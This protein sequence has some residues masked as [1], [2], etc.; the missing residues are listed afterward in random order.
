MMKEEVVWRCPYTDHSRGVFAFRPD[1]GRLAVGRAGG[2]VSV[3]DLKT[4]QP[5]NDVQL[6]QVREF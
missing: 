5:V 4:G 2:V 6:T 3:I 1:D